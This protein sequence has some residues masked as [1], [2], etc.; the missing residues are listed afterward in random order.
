MKEKLYYLVAGIVIGISITVVWFLVVEPAKVGPKGAVR[1]EK[2]VASTK[3]APK[4][5]EPESFMAS[6][7][8]PAAEY[9]QSAK[10]AVMALKK[11]EARVQSGIAYRDYR[12][13]LG[14]TKFSVNIYLDTSEAKIYPELTS[15]IE[16]VM[17]H[18]EQAGFVFEESLRGPY[19]YLDHVSSYSSEELRRQAISE[20]QIYKSLVEQYPEANKFIENGGALDRDKSD[21]GKDINNLKY[22][23]VLRLDYLLQMIFK[24]AS[25]DLENAS[26]LLSKANANVQDNQSDIETLKRE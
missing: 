16:R 10:E 11:M 2:Q 7:A 21:R 15:L 9:A 1:Q 6:A 25:K 4:R 22:G 3:Q 19:R 20:Q 5:S 14:E 12:P 24:R 18:Y 17:V 8:P 13:A 23:R 26:T